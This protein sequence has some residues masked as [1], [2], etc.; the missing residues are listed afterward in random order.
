M[1]PSAVAISAEL[2]KR[3]IDHTVVVAS[4]QRLK[5]PPQFYDVTSAI[6][7]PRVPES[8]WELVVKIADEYIE[9]ILAKLKRKAVNLKELRD[10]IRDTEYDK[11]KPYAFTWSNIYIMAAVHNNTNV[12]WLAS[13]MGR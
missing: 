5:R 8:L 9:P 2:A 13:V 4:S 10:T 11:L 7:E 12:Q 3:G 6:P 1:T